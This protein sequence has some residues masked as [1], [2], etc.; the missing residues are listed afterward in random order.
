MTHPPRWSALTAHD[1]MYISHVTH[2]IC[3]FYIVKCGDS[4][5]LHSPAEMMN[6]TWGVQVLR[7]PNFFLG[8]GSR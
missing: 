4:N 3:M 5:P 7:Y 2:L 8:N 1:N 6:S